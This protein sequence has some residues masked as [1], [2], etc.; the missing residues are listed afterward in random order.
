M[1]GTTNFSPAPLRPSPLAQF[2]A[3]NSFLC[4]FVDADLDGETDAEVAARFSREELPIGKTRALAEGRAL[5]A[6]PDAELPWRDLGDVAN[7]AITDAAAAR[8][9]HSTVLEAVAAAPPAAPPG[10]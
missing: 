8:T 5:L 9:W 6:R 3:L 2:P 4:W 7:R 10:E 1:P